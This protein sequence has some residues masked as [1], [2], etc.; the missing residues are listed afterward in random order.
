MR[1]PLFL[2]FALAR[3][4]GLLF[5]DI[6][7]VFIFIIGEA[8]TLFHR[9]DIFVKSLFVGFQLSAFH[10]KVAVVFRADFIYFLYGFQTAFLRQIFIFCYFYEFK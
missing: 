5:I 4:C 2:C 7:L 6:L 10:I 1:I 9:R 3:F 8:H